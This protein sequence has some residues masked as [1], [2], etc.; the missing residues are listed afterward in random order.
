V[1]GRRR[2]LQNDVQALGPLESL[3][4]SDLNDGMILGS[5]E[6]IV[7]REKFAR[8]FVHLDH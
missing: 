8:L 7:R 6:E 1:V 3:Y 5:L 2:L 4:V